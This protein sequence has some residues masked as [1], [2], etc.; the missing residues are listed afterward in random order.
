MKTLIINNY[1]SFT[2]N[3]YQYLGEL[4]GNPQVFRNDEITYTEIEKKKYS[5]IVISP[6]P[7][8]P[9]DKHYFGVCRE[10]ILRPDKNIPILG[11]CLGH[12]GIIHY[13]GGRIVRAGKIL[14]GKKSKITHNG[15]GIFK[16]VKSPLLG[17]RYHSL[18]GEKETIPDVLEITAETD[19]G[20]VMGVAHKQIPIFGIQFHPES[21]G[22][23]DGKK[24][25]K[26][27]LEF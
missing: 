16:E 1:D 27:F 14:H 20:V 15:D 19:D 6:G 2:Y 22:T 10:V 11:V 26:N 4:G 7:G 13:Y 3:L 23:E 9:S 24:I 5:H 18:V 8:D 17:M 12:Q 21:V 25:L